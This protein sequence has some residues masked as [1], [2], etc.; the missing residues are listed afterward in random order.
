MVFVRQALRAIADSNPESTGVEIH[1]EKLPCNNTFVHFELNNYGTALP[2]SVTG[3]ITL[4]KPYEPVYDTDDCLDSVTLDTCVVRCGSGWVPVSGAQGYDSTLT[5]TAGL[6]GGWP[7]HCR[8]NSTFV[9]VL[10]G[11]MPSCSP[12]RCLP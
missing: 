9:V 8:A 7:Y 1:C 3:S 10:D 2:P 6:N 4:M 5:T 11:P 12:S